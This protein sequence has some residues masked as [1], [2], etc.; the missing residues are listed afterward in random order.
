MRL[1]RIDCLLNDEVVLVRAN[2]APQA[3]K[4]VVEQQYRASVP[5]GIEVAALI[6]EGIEVQTAGREQG[7]LPEAGGE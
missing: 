4:H 2:T 1:Y 7:E 3:I 6:S 5:S